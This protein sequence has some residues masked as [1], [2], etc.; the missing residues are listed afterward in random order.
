V[1]KRICVI[2]AGLGGLSAAIR[3]ANKG[4]EVDLYE[5]NIYPGGKAGEIKEQ[6]YRFDTGPSLL[7]M[8]QVIKDLFAECNEN[9][10]DYLTINKLDLIC[11]YFYPDKSNINA[12]SDIEK[13]GIEIENKLLIILNH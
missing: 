6:G 5:Q 2:G 7:T 4:F 1:N 9:I 8:P 12:Y 3:L 11:K 10:D 13:F